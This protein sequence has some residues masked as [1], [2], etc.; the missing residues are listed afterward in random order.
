MSDMTGL[1]VCIW[2][3]SQET[4]PLFK[5]VYVHI[6]SHCQSLYVN[7]YTNTHMYM[8]NSM[9]A[10]GQSRRRYSRCTLCVHIVNIY[11]YIYVYIRTYICTCWTQRVHLVGVAGDTAVADVYTYVYNVC[12]YVYV[13]TYGI[14]Y[15]HMHACMYV[16]VY[17]Y[18]L[19]SMFLYTYLYCIPYAYGVALASRI[20]KL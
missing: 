12:M 10:P 11:I 2:L 18:M 20:N 9:C 7:I 16:F 8:L 5:C 4:Q 3:G 1:S 17:T 19:N 15:M 13:Q 14:L 6:Y